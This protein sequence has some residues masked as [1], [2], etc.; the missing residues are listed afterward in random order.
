MVLNNPTLS[1]SSRVSVIVADVDE[2]RTRLVLLNAMPTS[3][4]TGSWY[5]PPRPPLKNLFTAKVVV[6]GLF[7]MEFGTLFGG[8][9][10]WVP[11]RDHPKVI[12]SV[13]RR[14]ACTVIVLDS[15]SSPVGTTSYTAVSTGIYRRTS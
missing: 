6:G 15:I 8:L 2:L 4:P 7:K 1:G 10:S 13:F 3:E 14:E 12:F 11:A 9:P 5:K